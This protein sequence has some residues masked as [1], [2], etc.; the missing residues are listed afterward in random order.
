M[1]VA[2]VVAFAK[3]TIVVVEIIEE[4]VEPFVNFWDDCRGLELD[5]ILSCS[6]S[7]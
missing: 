2:I 5:Q 3:I 7:C 1:K 4:A 6:V